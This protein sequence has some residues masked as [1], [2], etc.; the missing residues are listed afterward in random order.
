MPKFPVYR[1]Y[2]NNKTFFK[3]LSEIEFEEIQ[4]IGSKWLIY[5]TVA[6]QYPEKLRIMDM[7]E[8]KDNVWVEISENDYE[9]QKKLLQIGRA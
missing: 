9:E 6:H 3:I 1:K 2:T 7:L 5:H 4:L 8:C